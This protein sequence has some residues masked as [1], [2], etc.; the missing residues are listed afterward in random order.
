MLLTMQKNDQV[1]QLALPDGRNW[2]YTVRR[3]ARSKNLRLRL[4]AEGQLLVTAPRWV[5]QSAVHQFVASRSLWIHEHLQRIGL[6]ASAPRQLPDRILLQAV[7]EQWEVTSLPG[8]GPLQLHATVE[9]DG[10]RLLRLHGQPAGFAAGQQLLRRWLAQQG[11]ARLLPW[12]AE[13]SA[14]TGLDYR[15]VSIRGQKTRWGSYSTRGDVSLNWKL[16]F[17]PPRLVRY[18]LIHELCHSLEMNHSDRF[19]QH[20][21]RFEADL[22]GTRR[23]MRV[24]AAHLPAW[25]EQGQVPLPRSRPLT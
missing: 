23:L 7:G 15:N 19:W 12:L 16:L 5:A 20:V 18:V 21:S 17:L 25:L 3:Y 2:P 24:A 9:P 4:N 6:K 1:F 8:D 13:V 22:P 11:R 14:E 10:S